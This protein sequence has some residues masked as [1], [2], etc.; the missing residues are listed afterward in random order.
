VERESKSS[1]KATEIEENIYK[2]GVKAFFLMD[3]KKI[4]IDQLL[5]ADKPLRSALELLVKCHDHA[6]YSR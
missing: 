2:I 3:A 1:K 4:N 5:V 6:K